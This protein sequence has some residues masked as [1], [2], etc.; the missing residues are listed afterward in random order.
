MEFTAPHLLALVRRWW[1]LLLLGPLVGGL[2]GYGVSSRVEPVYSSTVMIQV[3]PPQAGGPFDPD[4]LQSSQTLAMTY[5]QLIWTRPVLELVVDSL[6]L[7]YGVETLEERVSAWTLRGTQL[8]EVKVSDADAQQAADIANAIAAAFGTH[9]AAQSVQLGAP[10]RAVVD[11]QLAET[12]DQIDQIEQQ[13]AA[14]N[15]SPGSADLAVQQQVNTLGTTLVQLQQTSVELLIMQ[16][17]MEINAVGAQT[18]ITVA[19]A[20]EPATTP[21]EPRPRVAAAFG[22]V[23]GI[24]VAT[25]AVVVIGY[26]DNTVRTITSFAS[27]VG[28]PLIGRIG[29]QPKLREGNGQLFLVHHPNQEASEAIRLLRANIEF[30]SSAN[31]ITSLAVASPGRGEGKSTVIS[32][33]ALSMAQAGMR[34]ILIDADLRNPSQHRI[35]GIGNSLGLSSW[36]KRTTE[37]WLELA[38]ETTVRNLLVIPSGPVPSNPADLLSLGR[39]RQLLI[40]IGDS[41]DI[42][43]IDT[44]PVLD[45]S[46]ALLVAAEV[47]GVLLVSQYQRTRLGALRRAAAALRLSSARIVGV[48]LNQQPRRG[49]EIGSYDAD[50]AETTGAGRPHDTGH[51]PKPQIATP[52]TLHQSGAGDAR[53]TGTFGA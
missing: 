50:A 18:Q 21:D 36:L 3:N 42:V 49:L 47:D 13:I 9:I 20:A 41:A 30:A 1:W 37:P 25:A 19:A 38:S 45:S 29:Y 26:L 51:T 31:R 44:S 17:S 28:A 4:A 33:L 46:D 34:T 53:G 39:L 43:L 35:F 8:I 10:T 52:L 6:S 32:N 22:T 11:T 27:L 48:V 2:V 24:F 16:Q 7:P 12:T 15:Q 14:L 5:H 40:A 23:F